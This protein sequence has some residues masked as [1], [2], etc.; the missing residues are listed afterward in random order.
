MVIR[1]KKIAQGKAKLSAALTKEQ[2]AA[3]VEI[4]QA[5]AVYAKEIE[6]QEPDKEQ[7]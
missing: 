3:Q 7:T 6:G 1:N 4:E 2:A 5:Y